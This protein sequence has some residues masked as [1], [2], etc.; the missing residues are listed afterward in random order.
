MFKKENYPDD[1]KE[2]RKRIRI[3]AKDR[4]EICGVINH[5]I[6][7]RDKEGRFFEKEEWGDFYSY[8]AYKEIKII[9]TTAHLRH[10]H[11]K[12]DSDLLFLCQRCHLK[13]DIRY[14]IKN[15]KKNKLKKSGQLEFIE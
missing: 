15:I 5:M 11:Y 14:K 12:D 10:G 13:M 3:R 7:A 8:K 6:G 9:C 1:W 4:C 2:I